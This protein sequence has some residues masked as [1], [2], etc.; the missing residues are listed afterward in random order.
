MNVFPDLLQWSVQWSLYFHTA[1]RMHTNA[2]CFSGPVFDGIFHYNGT[3]LETVLYLI[4][5][6]A[7]ST[8][9]SIIV[10]ISSNEKA[11]SYFLFTSSMR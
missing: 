9:P 1:I 4:H 5:S 11:S 3:K 2:Q 10:S 8:Q 6:F 7:T